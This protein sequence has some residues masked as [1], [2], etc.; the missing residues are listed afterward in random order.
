M[1]NIF[2]VLAS[3]FCCLAGCTAQS[4]KYT[5]LDVA[6]FEKV[7]ASSGNVKLKSAYEQTKKTNEEI[8]RLRQ[9]ASS[10]EDLEHI[11]KLQQQIP[12]L[13]KIL[14]RKKK[15]PKAKHLSLK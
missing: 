13:R 2:L 15:C 6:E 12:S 14:I 10:D 3:M 8:G 7:V 9:T 11:L 1:R 5:S 4:D